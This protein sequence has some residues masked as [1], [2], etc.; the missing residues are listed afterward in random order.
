MILALA[1]CSPQDEP[2]EPETSET[3]TEAT[4]TETET[5]TTEAPTPTETETPPTVEE[6]HVAEAE[7]TVRDY[8][9]RADEVGA[10]GFAT[11]TDKL[12]MYWGSPEISN[13][14]GAA[15]Q[16]SADDS[17]RTQGSTAIP[18]MSLIEYIPDPSGAG[19]EQIRLQYCAD[20]SELST[21]DSG[22]MPIARTTPSRFT[23]E[24]LMQHQQTGNWTI[25]EAKALVEQSC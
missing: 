9:R 12:Y 25:N 17:K 11:W 14:M 2:G 24:V 1:G 21:L 6:Q 15:F 10:E 19:Y 8:H 4:P 16:S 7:Q 13:A 3:T 5:E 18:S 20:Y 22:G 23:W